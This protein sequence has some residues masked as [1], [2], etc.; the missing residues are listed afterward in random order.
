MEKDTDYQ[1]ILKGIIAIAH[2]MNYKVVA[3]GVEQE[4]N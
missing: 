3:E 4:N 2:S 1:A